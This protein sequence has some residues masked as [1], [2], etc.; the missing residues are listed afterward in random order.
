MVNNHYSR[1][2]YY[3]INEKLIED[4]ELFIWKKITTN[5]Q[6]EHLKLLEF[7][8]KKLFLPYIVDNFQRKYYIINN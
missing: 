5:K 1:E 4:L 6:K 3:N 2:P 8:Q 7:F